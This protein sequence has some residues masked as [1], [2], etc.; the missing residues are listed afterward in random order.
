MSI[1]NY[2]KIINHTYIILIVLFSFLI[3]WH[4]SKYGVFPIDSFLHY[5][6]AYRILNG[7]YPIKDFWVVSGVFVDFLQALFFKI[8]GVNWHSYIL[9]SSLINILISKL[10]DYP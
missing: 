2:K 7:E 6:S 10:T 8:L 3:N 1:F 5:D 9:H 4:Y